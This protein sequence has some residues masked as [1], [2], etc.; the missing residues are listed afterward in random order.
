MLMRKPDT[1]AVSTERLRTWRRSISGSATRSSKGI[2]TASR[3]T[4][5]ATTPRE[6]AEAQPHPPP[7]LSTTETPMTARLSRPAP[8]TS[9]RREVPA[10]RGG[11]T[12]AARTRAPVTVMAP[13]QYAARKPRSWAISPVTG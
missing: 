4:D 1:S 11:R 7:S 6:R 2:Q 10:E 13:N 9:K 5:A 12:S 8:T 3:T